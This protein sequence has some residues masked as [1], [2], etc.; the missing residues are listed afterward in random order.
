MLA[1]SPRE[2]IVGLSTRA[3]DADSRLRERARGLPLRR[4]T[5]E[6]VLAARP[7]IVVR[8]WGGDAKLLAALR[9]HGVTVVD[10]PEAQDFAEVRD[11]LRKVGVALG[12]PGPAE[13]LIGEMDARLAR[14]A[15][16][17]EGKRA[18]YVTPGGAT[19]GEGTLIGAMLKAAGLTSAAERPGYST[20]SLEAL[21]M[22]PPTAVVLGFFDSF[23]LANTYWGPGRHQALRRA[24]QGRTIASLPGAVLGCPGWFVAEAAETLALRA[25]K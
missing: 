2:A 3:D 18:L 21:A 22:R 17:W 10:V 13:A 4:S 5:L 19:A 15:G 1:L 16:A 14:A 7:D 6:S 11:G 20:V 12:R 25:P 24:A 9:R 23:M 8:H